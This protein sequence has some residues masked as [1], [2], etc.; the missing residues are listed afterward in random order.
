[1][2]QP[3]T[4]SSVYTRL[5]VHI[6]LVSHLYDAMPVALPIPNTITLTGTCGNCRKSVRAG[7]ASDNGEV[8]TWYHSTTGRDGCDQLPVK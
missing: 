3:T 7:I 1:M 5:D 2:D 8:F 6:G 4:R